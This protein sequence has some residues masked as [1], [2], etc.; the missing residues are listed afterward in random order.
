[1]LKQV[2]F[3][4]SVVPVPS[5]RPCRM[6]YVETLGEMADH[7]WVPG[8]VTYPFTGGEQFTDL[9]VLRRRGKQREKDYKYTVT[10]YRQLSTSVAFN[11]DR[12][13]CCC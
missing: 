12:I 7:A 6:Y 2:V 13:V 1:M 5:R 4:F 10:N 11:L 8:K 3:V 9:P